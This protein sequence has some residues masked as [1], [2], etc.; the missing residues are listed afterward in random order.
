MTQPVGV[1]TRFVFYVAHRGGL[2]VV[3]LD[4]RTGKTLWAA[5]ATPSVIAPG[6]APGLAVIGSDVFYLGKGGGSLAKLVA[7]TH[8]VSSTAKVRDMSFA[9][10]AR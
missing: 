5:P 7:F 8:A 1:G 10:A 3:A 4:A 2:R 9:T 6:V